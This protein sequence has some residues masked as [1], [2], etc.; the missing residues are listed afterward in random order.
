MLRDSNYSSCLTISSLPTH[1]STPGKTKEE[2]EVIVD[3]WNHEWYSRSYSDRPSKEECL[4]LGSP[5]P[6]TPRRS[7]DMWNTD[8]HAANHGVKARRMTKEDFM[9]KSWITESSKKETDL[10]ARPKTL[11]PKKKI[12][13]RLEEK[14]LA[15]IAHK[16]TDKRRAASDELMRDS[17]P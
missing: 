1:K 17:F 9:T 10:K 13:V 16:S 7:S 14:V 15:F 2:K 11:D 5:K 6:C 8:W 3:G 4:N 12:A